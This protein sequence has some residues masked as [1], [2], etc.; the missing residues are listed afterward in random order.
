MKRILAIGGVAVAAVLAVLGIAE[1]RRRRKP[2]AEQ[3]A[4]DEPPT[5]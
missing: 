3:A 4:R 2:A 5:G 1:A